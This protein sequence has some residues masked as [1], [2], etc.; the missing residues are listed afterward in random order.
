MK[1]SLPA[2]QARPEDARFGPDGYLLDP[3]DWSEALARALAA[4]DGVELD[5][6][7]WWLV[8]FVRKHYLRYGTPPL[9]RIIVREMRAQG[10]DSEASSRTLYRLFPDGPLRSACRYAGLAKPEACI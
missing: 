7:R 8:C 4:A 5:R 9:L 2:A 6:S 3:D 1:P 10:V